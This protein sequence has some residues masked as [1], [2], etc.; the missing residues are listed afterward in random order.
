MKKPRIYFK[1]KFLI[2][3]PF[4]LLSQNFE[5]I[6]YYKNEEDFKKDIRI[7]LIE[8]SKITHTGF[9]FKG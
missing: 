9:V 2:F 6:R 1:M 5:F 4:I 8:A 3:F 7:N